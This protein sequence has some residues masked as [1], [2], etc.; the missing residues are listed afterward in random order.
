MTGAAM[1][2][3]AAAGGNI[4]Y[5][6]DDYPSLQNGYTVT[7]TITTDGNTGT[8]GLLD[9]KS[10]DISVLKSGVTQ[11]TLTQSNTNAL[12]V[13]ITATATALTVSGSGENLLFEEQSPISH[14]FIYLIGWSGPSTN[15]YEAWDVPAQTTPL[16]GST[17]PSTNVIASVPELSAFMQLALGALGAGAFI[18]RAWS[19]HRRPHRG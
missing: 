19:R 15:L 17:W 16:W 11:F 9:L 12:G 10:W 8:L 1:P 3:P 7:G 18:A 2:L 4:T 14:V 13:N 6:V 5:Y